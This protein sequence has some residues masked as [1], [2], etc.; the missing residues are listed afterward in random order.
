MP[1]YTIGNT[2]LLYK[3]EDEIG[4]EDSKL[5][6]AK[7]KQTALTSPMLGFTFNSEPVK[8]EIAAIGNISEAMSSRIFTGEDDPATAI[9]TYIAKCKAAGL[10]KVLAEMQK[11]LDAWKKT[12]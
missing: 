7:I 8:T 9:P 5:F 3:T 4:G 12:K 6:M 10:D 11:Q 2:A 1:N